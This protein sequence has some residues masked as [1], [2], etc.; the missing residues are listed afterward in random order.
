[1]MNIKSI[2]RSIR[3]FPI[4]LRKDTITSSYSENIEINA[5]Q[6]GRNTEHLMIIPTPYA[7]PIIMPIYVNERVARELI[8]DRYYILP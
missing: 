1:M 8:K 2:I 7:L 6:Y 3:A 5:A 4:Q